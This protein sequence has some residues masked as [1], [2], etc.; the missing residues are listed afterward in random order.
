MRLGNSVLSN[1]LEGLN[2]NNCKIT[3]EGLK[4]LPWSKLKYIGFKGCRLNGKK[5]KKRNME[6]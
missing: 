6:L 4:Y 3:Y 2:L 5:K 1:V